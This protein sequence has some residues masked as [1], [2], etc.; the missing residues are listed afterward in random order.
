MLIAKKGIRIQVLKTK[1][2]KKFYWNFFNFSFFVG[3][4]CLP[5]LDAETGSTS[6]NESG[7][8]P[9]TDTKL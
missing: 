1:T 5:D 2:S 9:D 7:F 4:L 6:A 3:Q 8:N